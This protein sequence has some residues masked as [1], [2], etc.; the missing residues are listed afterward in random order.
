MAK[1]KRPTDTDEQRLHTL[2]LFLR[3]GKINSLSVVGACQLWQL[4]WAIFWVTVFEN[5]VEF[6][7][8]TMFKKKKNC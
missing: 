3:G 6:C 2:L 1:E 8:A 7:A 5:N 4:K